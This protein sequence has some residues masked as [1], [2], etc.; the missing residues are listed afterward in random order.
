MERNQN[1]NMKE[2]KLGQEKAGEKS[3]E[4]V[5]SEP[6]KPTTSDLPAHSLRLRANTEESLPNDP[7]VSS[8]KSGVRSRV[9]P[10]RFT[11][12]EK[13][14]L[15]GTSKDRNI[16]L[17]E[18]VR[19]C[20][21]GRKIPQRGVPEINRNAYTELCRIGN[22]LNQI[23]RNL[24]RGYLSDSLMENLNNLKSLV[25]ELGLQLLGSRG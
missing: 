19:R 22:N 8:E 20:A 7:T 1:K 25:K 14:L 23:S 21:L 11:L 17:S 6:C 18:F 24:N 4:S 16:S 5:G 3:C 2:E 13:T 9:V 15:M 10:I 12:A